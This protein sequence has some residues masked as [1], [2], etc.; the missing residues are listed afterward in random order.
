[1]LTFEVLFGDLGVAAS[2]VEVVTDTT[3]RSQT[4]K[5]RSARARHFVFGIVLDAITLWTRRVIDDS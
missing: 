4:E 3:G 1:M 5:E 2:S